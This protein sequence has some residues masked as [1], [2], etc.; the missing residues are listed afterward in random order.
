MSSEDCATT[1]PSI[2]MVVQRY[3]TA[4][5]RINE[6][7]E[8]TVGER[9][10]ANTGSHIGMLVYVSFSRTA[11]P[12][13]VERASKT[14]LNLPIQTEGAWGDESSTVSILQAASSESSTV[15]VML[16]P[17]ANMI[18]SIKKNGK[19]IQY[20]N[21]IDKT[22]G[23]ELYD[24]FV[25]TVEKMLVDHQQ[26]IRGAPRSKAGTNNNTVD[27]SIPP[28]E[29]FQ[30]EKKYGSFDESTGFPLTDADGQPLTKSA[31][32]RIRKLY[33][34]HSK[35]HEKWLSRKNEAQSSVE[36]FHPP[37]TSTNKE[38]GL[39]QSFVQLVAGSFGKRQGLELVSDMGPFC[40]VIEL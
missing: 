36:I 15:S 5:L 13:E 28:E 10:G 8:V 34:A 17:Q 11:T 7:R 33:D 38:I 2:R 23:E 9:L 19:S 27:S 3:R 24:M 4:S 31:L 30:Q 22:R 12:I 39:D 20:H 40:H 1:G 21:Q 32:K 37:T 18:A 14:I 35:R 16:V 29:F 25:D 26:C 6:N